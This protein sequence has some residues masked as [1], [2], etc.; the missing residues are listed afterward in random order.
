[1]PSIQP[2]HYL[3][4]SSLFFSSCRYTARYA[5]HLLKTTLSPFSLA[6]GW[7]HRRGR[8]T[9]PCVKCIPYTYPLKS[10]HVGGFG[11]IHSEPETHLKTRNSNMITAISCNSIRRKLTAN[12]SRDIGFDWN[13]K[14]YETTTSSRS[15][16][17]VVDIPMFECHLAKSMSQHMA[18]HPFL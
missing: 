2:Y 3:I 17:C 13:T 8:V 15:K 7:L 10:E 5:V 6:F 12:Y 9:S 16:L 18:I 1:M 14:M 4:F 11:P